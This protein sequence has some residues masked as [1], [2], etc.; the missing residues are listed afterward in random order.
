[1]AIMATVVAVGLLV[2]TATLAARSSKNG[3][4]TGERSGYN[5]INSQARAGGCNGTRLDMAT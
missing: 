1:M 2:Q 3:T 4:N 5:S